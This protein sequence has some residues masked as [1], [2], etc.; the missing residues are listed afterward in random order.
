MHH[1]VTLFSRRAQTVHPHTG[2]V[3]VE[4]FYQ[5]PKTMA[6]PRRFMFFFC[7]RGKLGEVTIGYYVTKVLN[8]V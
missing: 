6:A 2:T 7:G 1:L 4:R 3:C 5:A 8:R